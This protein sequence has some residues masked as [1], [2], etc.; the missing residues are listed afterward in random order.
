METFTRDV[1]Q[2]WFSPYPFCCRILTGVFENSRNQGQGVSITVT[3]EEGNLVYAWA[4]GRL[5]RKN[6]LLV[7][8]ELIRNALLNAMDNNFLVIEVQS[9]N[10]LLFS[11]L[12]SGTQV[13]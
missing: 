1:Q 9:S 11:M 12:N 5:E 13:V 7:E 8:A 3:N 4:E 6:S 10:P 2:L